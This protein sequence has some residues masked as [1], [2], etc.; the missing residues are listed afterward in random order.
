M[1]TTLVYVRWFDS[2]IFKGEQSA[3]D[4]IDIGVSEMESAGLLLREDE[5]SI[6]IAL[7]RDVED[8]TVRLLLCV[9][10]VCVR[11]MRRF[12]IAPAMTADEVAAFDRGDHFKAIAQ[13]AKG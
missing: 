12:T 4:E 9:P 13:E 11:E 5:Q 10:K 8:R 6:T 3:L 7:D 1:P 2:S